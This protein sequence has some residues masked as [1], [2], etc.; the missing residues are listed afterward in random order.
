MQGVNG[1]VGRSFRTQIL[2]RYH[3]FHTAHQAHHTVTPAPHTL[4]PVS[5]LFSFPSAAAA[6][7][8]AVSQN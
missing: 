3:Q 1:A 7:K 5:P 8:L 4:T 6:L 2:H